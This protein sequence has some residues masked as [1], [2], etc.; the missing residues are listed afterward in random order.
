[1]ELVVW[2]EGGHLKRIDCSRS[3][4]TGRKH[5]VLRSGGIDMLHMK[6]VEHEQEG[7]C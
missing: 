6:M 2:L 7:S 4:G 1:V 5:P 3:F